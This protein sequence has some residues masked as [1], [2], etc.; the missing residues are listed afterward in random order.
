MAQGLH[1]LLKVFALECLVMGASGL[2]VRVSPRVSQGDADCSNFGRWPRVRQRLLKNRCSWRENSRETIDRREFS[3]ESSAPFPMFSFR[4]LDASAGNCERRRF[5][6]LCPA[7]L[8][9]CSTL[10]RTD[11]K[12]HDMFAGDAKSRLGKCEDGYGMVLRSKQACVSPTRFRHF[13][14]PSPTSRCGG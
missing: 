14:R 10:A 6:D 11:K 8:R 5:A 4:Y 3:R 2:L 1:S 13:S 9:S 7:V 12:T